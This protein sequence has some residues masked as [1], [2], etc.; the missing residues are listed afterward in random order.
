MLCD[1]ISFKP[2]DI[3]TTVISNQAPEKPKSSKDRVPSAIS[4]CD[5]ED[6]CQQVLSGQNIPAR[7][8]IY[9]QSLKICGYSRIKSGQHRTRL[10]TGILRWWGG[11]LE[12]LDRGEEG[13]GGGRVTWRYL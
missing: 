9:S 12:M 11:V 6:F 1:V 13:K 8:M 2:C 10:I 7:E 3:G 5:N 4:L